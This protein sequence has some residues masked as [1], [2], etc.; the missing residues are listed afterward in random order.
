MIVL[1][2]ITKM[3]IDVNPTTSSEIKVLKI[4]FNGFILLFFQNIDV[5]HIKEFLLFFQAI[6]YDLYYGIINIRYVFDVVTFCVVVFVALFD[7]H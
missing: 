7:F 2:R 4:G 5:F 6:L 1:L 3:L